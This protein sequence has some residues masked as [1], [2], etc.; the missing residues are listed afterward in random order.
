LIQTVFHRPITT[1][2]SGNLQ[3]KLRRRSS[4]AHRTLPWF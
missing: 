3:E 4:L 2:T 1:V